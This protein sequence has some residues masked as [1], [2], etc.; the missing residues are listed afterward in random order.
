MPCSSH[1]SKISRSSRPASIGVQLPGD[2]VFVHLPV[3]PEGISV[4]DLRARARKTTASHIPSAAHLG[5]QAGKSFLRE[6]LGLTTQYG[7]IAVDENGRFYPVPEKVRGAFTELSHDLLML[8]A[9][10][11]Y[12][13]ARLMAEQYGSVSPQ[14]GAALA[15]LSDIPVDID[16]VFPLAG[17]T[18]LDLDLKRPRRVRAEIEDRLL[19]ICVP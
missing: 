12:E 17:L 8:Q 15:S 18:D 1:G 2:P 5:A 9:E 4:L 16:P 10:G 19:C 7:S 14:L 6:P 13:K 11:S 3:F